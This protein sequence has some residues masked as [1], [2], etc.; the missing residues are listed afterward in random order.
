MFSLSTPL[1]FY[2]KAL[3]W[4]FCWKTEGIAVLTLTIKLASQVGSRGG[5]ERE[6]NVS[7][8]ISSQVIE[9]DSHLLLLT[10]VKYFLA[11]FHFILFYGDEFP[12]SLQ[13]LVV[14]IKLQQTLSFSEPDFLGLK[15]QEQNWSVLGACLYFT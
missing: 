7:S 13:Y 14:K 3:H 15:I 4:S 6:I 12:H 8:V 1:P 11:R 2:T 5:L 9:S 10:A